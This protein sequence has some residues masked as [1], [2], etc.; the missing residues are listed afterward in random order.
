M[1]G[2]GEEVGGDP[3]GIVVAVGDDQ[4]L[5]RAGDHV[6]A[7]R[8]EHLALGGGDVGVARPDDLGDRRDRRRAVGERGDRLGAADAVDLV[9]A[10]E[11]G[12]GEHQRV[13]AC[14]RAPA[15]TMTTRSTPATF[16]GTAFI[17]TELG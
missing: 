3:V 10:G 4:D 16:A 9:D 17:R 2:L 13:D 12:G 14:R 7:D 6:D 15:T 1:L 11:P 8:A 5:A